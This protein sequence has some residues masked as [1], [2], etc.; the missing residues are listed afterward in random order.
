MIKERVK[1]L[2]MSIL[3]SYRIFIYIQRKY[4]LCYSSTKKKYI[5][6]LGT[7]PSLKDSLNSLLSNDIGETDFFAVNNFAISKYYPIVKPKFYILLDPAYWLPYNQTNDY[8]VKERE[9]IF[10]DLNDKT[11]WSMDLFIPSNIYKKGVLKSKIINRNI[12]VR[13]INYTNFYPTDSWFYHSIILKQNF[14]VVPVGNVLGQAIYASIN[15]G[16]EKITLLGAEHS[17]TK[18]LR[19]NVDNQVCTIRRHFYDGGIEGVLIPWQKSNGKPFRMYEI[20]RSISNHF[21]GYEVLN[22]YA[23]RLNVRIYNYT[24]ESFI[25]AFE[26]TH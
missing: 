25:D 21:Y 5:Y 18:D 8:D 7:G 15:L 24:P 13:A 22:R 19:V 9:A 2:F 10:S 11:S 12:K 3:Y 16:Y 4:R 6:V 14:G 1:A 23:K 26:R 17:W 20:L